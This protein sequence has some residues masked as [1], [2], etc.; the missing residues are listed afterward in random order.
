[1]DHNGSIADVAVVWADMRRRKKVRGFLVEKGTPGFSTKTF[2]EN[3]L[4]ASVTSSLALSDASS[5]RK[6]AAALRT[7]RS[8]LVPESGAY[9]SDGRHWR[10]HGLLPIRARLCDS[11]GSNSK[12]ARSRRTSSYRKLVW[13]I[14]E[15]TKASS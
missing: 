10:S 13:M 11:S 8:A 12:I 9:A 14:T 4:R 3:I 7:Q 6:S 15:I 1:V 5:R 2:T